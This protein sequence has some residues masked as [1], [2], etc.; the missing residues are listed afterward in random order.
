MQR[1]M[2]RMRAAAA[3]YRQRATGV[4]RGVT[5]VE[6]A[7]MMLAFLIAVLGMIEVG[8]AVFR[9]HVVGQA[10]RQGARLAMVRGELAPPELPAWGPATYTGAASSSDAIPT[11]IRPYLAGLDVASTNIRM[12]WLDGDT[13]VGSRVRVVISTPHRP[14]ITYP[15]GGSGWTLNGSSTMHIAH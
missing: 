1:H 13:E 9:H 3:A 14:F 8:M 7:L 6:S 2:S 11:A 10:A 5:M 4:R 12:E 15:L